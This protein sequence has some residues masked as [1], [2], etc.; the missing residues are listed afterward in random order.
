MFWVS[1]GPGGDPQRGPKWRCVAKMW[2][3]LAADSQR[4]NGPCTSSLALMYAAVGGLYQHPPPG[5]LFFFWQPRE[6]EHISLFW[7]RI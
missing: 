5:V 1:W 6:D 7:E 2:R 3:S 4:P